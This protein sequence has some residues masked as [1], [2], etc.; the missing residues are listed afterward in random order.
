[1][2]S[3][4]WMLTVLY[5]LCDG[6]HTDKQADDAAPMRDNA[7]NGG[8]NSPIKNGQFPNTNPRLN[9]EEL[10]SPSNVSRVFDLIHQDIWEH[11]SEVPNQHNIY[12]GTRYIDSTDSKLLHSVMESLDNISSSW[13]N[14]KLQQQSIESQN[15][16]R[17]NGASLWVGDKMFTAGLADG[18]MDAVIFET[19][20][21]HSNEHCFQGVSAE[22]GAQNG[23]FSSN[24]WFFTHY[25]GWHSVL[26]EA[27]PTC[28]GL[29]TEWMEEP[30]YHKYDDERLQVFHG[31][32]C[33]STQDLTDTRAV[34]GEDNK[35]HVFRCSTKIQKY[36]NWTPQ[37]SVPCLSLEDWIDKAGHDHVDY[38]S[39]DCEG[40]EPGPLRSIE[41]R[42]L[43]TG[44]V[45]VEWNGLQDPQWFLNHMK[46]QGFFGVPMPDGVNRTY[47]QNM[48]FYSPQY[49][50]QKY[51]EDGIQLTSI[52][53][54]LEG[55]L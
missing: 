50:Q 42:K 39:M 34:V 24:T 43:N 4:V 49:F 35:G 20:F 40:C 52:K 3:G 16:K 18:V 21:K 25:L 48:V 19:F 10:L 36:R 47:T 17:N 38:V 22:F 12:W 37:Q 46:D 1:M 14:L 15:D 9:F 2:L 44:V 11:S 33:D 29:V 5:L 28:F 32:V 7:S 53:D 45:V 23:M 6:V 54:Y 27:S 13:N 8:Q 51:D 30:F 41:W 31:G 26:I 55:E